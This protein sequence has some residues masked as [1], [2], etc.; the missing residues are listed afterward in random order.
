MYLFNFN[1]HRQSDISY[2]LNRHNTIS[3][4]INVLQPTININ[5]IIN[6]TNF[7]STTFLN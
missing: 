5:I 4:N 2:M 6:F 3:Y 1:V 7:P